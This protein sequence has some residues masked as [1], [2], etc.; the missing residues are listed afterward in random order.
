MLYNINPPTLQQILDILNEE[1][2][3][4]NAN[5]G[6]HKDADSI[7]DETRKERRCFKRNEKRY[8]YNQKQTVDMFVT[9]NE[10]ND[11]VVFNTDDI[12]WAMDV[13]DKEDGE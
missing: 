3:W 11:F 6:L 10:E 4:G 5:I 8:T 12:Q 2:N 13:E 7:T 1:E 9:Y